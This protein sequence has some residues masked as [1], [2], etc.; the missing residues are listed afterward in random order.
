MIKGVIFDLGGVLVDNPAAAMRSFI[1]GILGISESEFVKRSS[2]GIID[3]Q[4]GLISE[5]KFWEEVTEGLEVKE[6]LPD[7]LWK[8]A[9]RQAFV[10]K[11]EML[12]LIA[13]LKKIG[14][15]IGILS[16]TEVPVVEYLQEIGFESF[17]VTVFSCLEKTCKPERDIYLL[18]V[19]RMD[20]KPYELVFIDDALENVAAG[21]SIGLNCIHFRNTNQVKEDLMTLIIV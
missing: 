9:I 1:S 2:S 8:E 15:S 12:S 21:Q 16:N 11:P 7:S 10:P 18:T 13:E 5:E 17:D 14:I 4:K 6:N 19:E 20:M 3:F